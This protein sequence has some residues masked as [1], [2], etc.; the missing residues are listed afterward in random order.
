MMLIVVLSLSV[1]VVLAEE[2]T[3]F[4]IEKGAHYLGGKG[5]YAGYIVTES[6]T[7]EMRISASGDEKV[8]P[9]KEVR[10]I[11]AESKDAYDSGVK[12]IIIDGTKIEKIKEGTPDYYH[13]TGGPFGEPDYY[14]YN[15]EYVI[16]EL[17]Y[18]EHHYPDGWYK[19]SVTIEFAA[20]ANDKSKVVLLCYGLDANGNP[21]E[22]PF[23]QGT[24]FVVPEYVTPIL[25]V[26]ACFAAYVAFKSRA[27]AKS[28]S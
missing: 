12:S 25:G 3:F 16:A 6:G 1:G 28:P 21:V 11:V 8:F 17:T 15:D 19:L 7:F 2:S 18:K 22:T 24:L 27:F 14:G 20:D 26:A 10:V 13:A 9:I 4:V 5:W 23:N